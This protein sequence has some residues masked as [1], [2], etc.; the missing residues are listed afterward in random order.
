MKQDISDYLEGLSGAT[1]HALARI[2]FIG[3]ILNAYETFS[4]SKFDREVRQ[5]LKYID[6]KVEDINALF[7]EAWLKTDEGQQFAWKVVDSALDTQ[8]E[9]KQELFVNA[10]INGIRKPKVSQLE[11][12]KFIDI[13]RHLS[14]A[15][16]M[17]LADMHN[18]FKDKVRGPGRKPKGNPPYPVVDPSDI[19]RKLASKYNPY[20]VMACIHEMVSEGL[21]SNIAEWS[22]NKPGSGIVS[23][24]FADALSYNHFT[25]KFVEFI[26]LRETQEGCDENLSK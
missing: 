3:E 6:N 22:E 20:L 8:M 7:S 16:L 21:F 15:S 26:T 18:M 4:R 2:P 1:K 25:A 14:R 12:L 17:V 23:Q 5:F 11:K 9:D 24:G 19:A 13:L 10:L